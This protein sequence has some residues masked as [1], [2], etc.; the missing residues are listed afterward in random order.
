MIRQ[1]NNICYTKISVA[2]N[3]EEHLFICKKNDFGKYYIP[4]GAKSL[5]T[6]DSKTEKQA[7]TFKSCIPRDIFTL[8]VKRG[9]F[10]RED[11]HKM[12]I[13]HMLDGYTES[14]PKNICCKCLN[15]VLPV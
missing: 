4:K 12:F 15:V 6:L 3:T 10:F 11:Y 5:C 13:M 2:G 1:K 7:I 14:M 8:E 9:I